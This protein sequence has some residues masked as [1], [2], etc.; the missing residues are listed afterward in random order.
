MNMASDE[1]GQMTERAAILGGPLGFSQKR[2]EKF[3][4]PLD[5]SEIFRYSN[6]CLFKQTT[7]GGVAQLAR[8][9]GSYP[10]CHR[11]KSSRRYQMGNLPIRQVSTYGPL[12]K[13]LR[14]RPFTAVTRVRVS[15]GS[16]RKRTRLGRVLFSL[17]WPCIMGTP[18]TA[19]PPG[20][21]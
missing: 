13:W 8:A 7:Y 10:K 9:F 20:C 14:H 16:P 4:K 1:L 3:P 15:Y 6:P 2:V 19:P 18:L 17:Q 12:V 21:W 5:K 11:F